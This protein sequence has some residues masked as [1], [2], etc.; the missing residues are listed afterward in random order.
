M[1]AYPIRFRHHPLVICTGS[2]RVGRRCGREN[3][4]RHGDPR[5]ADPRRP[6][7]VR[8]VGWKQ[9]EQT[10][11]GRYLPTRAKDILPLLAEGMQPEL[12]GSGVTLRARIA[13]WHLDVIDTAEPS[14][15]V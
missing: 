13:F 10:G 15:R 7:P 14:A 12:D 2:L 9:Q 11:L 4:E 1:L 6:G 3:V 8:V 5:L